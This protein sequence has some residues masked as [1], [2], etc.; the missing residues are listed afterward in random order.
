MVT[1]VLDEEDRRVLDLLREYGSDEQ[2]RRYEALLSGGSTVTRQPDS[3]PASAPGTVPIADAATQLGL[4]IPEV[5]RHVEL[6]LLTVEPRA[7]RGEP[8]ITNASIAWLL[9]AKRDLAK[10]VPFPWE[11]D[12][13]IE[14]DSLLGQMMAASRR[15]DATEE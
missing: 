3:A 6:G 8:F 2:V 10:I 5:R 15:S 7:E 9:D 11:D 13:L 12:D 4:T 14:P 1:R